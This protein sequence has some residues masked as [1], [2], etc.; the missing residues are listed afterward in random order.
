LKSCIQCH[1]APG[2]FSVLSM[3]RG[4][5]EANYESFRTYAWDV[6]LNYTVRAKTQRFDWGLLQGLLEAER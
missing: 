6:E 4:L 3:Q 1:Q 2:I 5:R